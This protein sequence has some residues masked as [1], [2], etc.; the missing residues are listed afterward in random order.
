[1]V[2]AYDRKENTLIVFYNPSLINSVAQ[3]HTLDHVILG[4]KGFILSKALM[5]FVVVVVVNGTIKL[6]F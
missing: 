2:G 3:A 6:K 1:M 4:E 5:L